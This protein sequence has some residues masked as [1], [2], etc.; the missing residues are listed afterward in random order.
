MSSAA[1]PAWVPTRPGSRASSLPPTS[2]RRCSTRSGRRSPPP[3]S[4]AICCRPGP[5]S[6]RYGGHLFGDRRVADCCCAAATAASSADG[7]E[8]RRP[9]AARRGVVPHRRADPHATATSS[10]TRLRTSR[11]C[12]S[13]WWPAGRRRARSPCSATWPRPPGPGPTPTGSE[14]RA[15][16]PDAAPG[17]HDELTLGYRAPGRVLDYA[18]RLL[19]LAAPGITPDL[20]HPGRAHGPGHTRRWSR[21]SSHRPH[22]PRPSAGRPPRAGGGH[23]PRRARRR[24]SP[25]WH[26]TTA[27]SASSSATP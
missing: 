13:A 8:R 16:L 12:S 5:N 11:R 20:L 9:R 27:T 18:S 17:E 15:H 4:S 3:R 19:P 2:S 21:T 24:P 25:G 22:S 14:V 1:R 26:G 7:L 6:T 10:S 23:R